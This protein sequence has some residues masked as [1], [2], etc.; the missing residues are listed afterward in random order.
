MVRFLLTIWATAF[1][2]G[3][4]SGQSVFAQTEPEWAAKPVQ[5]GTPYEVFSQ[6]K[7]KGMSTFF[8][9]MGITTSVNYDE[10]LEVFMFVSINLE[11]QQWSAI[12]VNDD[13][14]SACIIGFGQG[15]LFDPNELQEYTDPENFQ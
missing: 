9:G 8:G 10:P 13:K 14:T 15:T 3:I 12:E 2:G 5:C 11:T 6:V 1:L 7:E 4:L